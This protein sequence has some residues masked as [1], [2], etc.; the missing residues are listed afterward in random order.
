MKYWSE[1][2]GQLFD[3]E[4]ALKEAEQKH[5]DKQKERIVMHN[6]V[7]DA[8]YRSKEAQKEYANL[9]SEYTKKYG[10]FIYSQN[11]NENVS[12][13]TTENIFDSPFFNL[14]KR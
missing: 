8:L 6:K 12:T 4:E 10:A 11:G 3:S 14:F 7:M 9:L 5:E 1:A 2:L 13:I